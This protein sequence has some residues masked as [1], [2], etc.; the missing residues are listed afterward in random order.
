MNLGDFSIIGGTTGG[1]TATWEGDYG[2]IYEFIKIIERLFQAIMNIFNGISGGI[3]SDGTE[4][5]DAGEGGEGDAVVPE[6]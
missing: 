4:T 2:Y 5:P 6:A 1:N 3:G